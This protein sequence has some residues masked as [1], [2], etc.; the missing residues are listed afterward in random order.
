MG[1]SESNEEAAAAPHEQ[2]IEL[3]NVFHKMSKYALLHLTVN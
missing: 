2:G 3:W 1:L